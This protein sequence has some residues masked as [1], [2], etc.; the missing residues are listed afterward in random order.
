VIAVASKMES[1]AGRRVVAAQP[2]PRRLASPS[3]SGGVKCQN[4]PGADPCTGT[5]GVHWLQGTIP[6]DRVDRVADIIQGYW[7]AAASEDRDRGRYRYDR[8]VVWEPFGIALYF[9]S[10]EERSREAHAGRAAL[11]IPGSALDML[12]GD[13]LYGLIRDLIGKVYLKAT[14]L[15]CCFD[16]YRRVRNP[17]QIAEECARGNF[18]RYRI[19]EHR[20]PSNRVGE[21]HADMVSFGRRGKGGGGTFLRIYDKALESDGQ[22]DC[23]RWE[24]EF[25]KE[26]AQRVLFRLGFECQS[27]EDFAATVGAL[28]A[29]SI[30]FVNREASR[31]RHLDRLKPLAWW[32]QLCELLGQ[33]RLRNAA[34]DRSLEKTSNWMA[35][36]LKVCLWLLAEKDGDGAFRRWLDDVIEEGRAAAK[37][38]HRAMLHSYWENHKVHGGEAPF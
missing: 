9:D 19:W 5:V 17:Y 12:T 10:C 3:L 25:S 2:R 36:D 8:S 15:D 37:P 18:T 29:G 1:L 31:T 6:A 13:Q 24:V 14:R 34:P 35:Q 33:V 26:Q 16:D 23:V 28:V 4:A 22:R 32:E 38:R 27:V 20:A 21:R 30:D 11:A 7:E